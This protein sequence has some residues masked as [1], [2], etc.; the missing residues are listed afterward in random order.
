MKLW[1]YPKQPDIIGTDG[2]YS[3]LGKPVILQKP[4]SGRCLEFLRVDDYGFYGEA[5]NKMDRI[6]DGDKV[7]IFINGPEKNIRF[8]QFCN[9]FYIRR[10]AI[11]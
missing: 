7:G 10:C 8:F 11:A 3:N 2:L 4:A 6:E 9:A 1:K 5:E